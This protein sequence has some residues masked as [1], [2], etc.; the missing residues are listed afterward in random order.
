MIVQSEQPKKK[1]TK[2]KASE[3][4]K[5]TQKKSN[6]QVIDLEAGNIE[7]PAKKS[8]KIIET[9]KPKVT[10]PTADPESIDYIPSLSKQCIYL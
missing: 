9:A 7:K 4:K 10:K 6:V 5:S 8:V 1:E 3:S 2:K